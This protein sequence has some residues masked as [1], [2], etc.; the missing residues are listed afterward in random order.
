MLGVDSF[1]NRIRSVVLLYDKTFKYSG[2]HELSNLLV[3]RLGIL[4]YL[5]Y[6]IPGILTLILSITPTA[7]FLF[8]PIGRL[9]S[10]LPALTYLTFLI[11]HLYHYRV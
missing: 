3:P 7:D 5:S 8:V 11:V 2:C 9:K 1:N 4:L 6:N 10:F